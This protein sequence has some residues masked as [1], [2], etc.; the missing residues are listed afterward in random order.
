[1]SMISR[2]NRVISA[3]MLKDPK[4]HEAERACRLSKFCYNTV[5]EH[6]NNPKDTFE[7]ELTQLY[8]RSVD[9]DYS[10]IN[11]IN[12]TIMGGPVQANVYHSYTHH[13]IRFV[14]GAGP[15]EVKPNPDNTSPTKDLYSTGNGAGPFRK[16]V[17]NNTVQQLFEMMNGDRIKEQS[18]FETYFS[19]T[20]DGLVILL[21]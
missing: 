4:C 5:M 16:T 13:G 21:I 12:T 11:T 3:A 10:L 6:L 2:R 17:G 15:A 9:N 19:F 7:R 14:F 18:G 8:Q 20:Q 1:M